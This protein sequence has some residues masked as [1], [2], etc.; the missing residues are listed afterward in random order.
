MNHL[1]FAIQLAIHHMSYYYWPCAAI[2][3]H[4]IH[5]LACH[6]LACQ[7]P[8]FLP[9]LSR[10]YGR[11]LLHKSV[12]HVTD[13]HPPLSVPSFLLV[14]R[15]FN[16]NFQSCPNHGVF[17]DAGNFGHRST[18]NFRHRSEAVACACSAVNSSLSTTVSRSSQCV[19]THS[20]NTSQVQ[21]RPSTNKNSSPF[22]LKRGGAGLVSK[23]K[24]TAW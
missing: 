1:L 11:S 18:N 5:Y 13:L 8:C 4:A 21:M 6:Y 20:T 9:C 23:T 14:V 19:T 15:W 16:V 12:R 2:C 7:L 10:S 17:D 22:F 24:R 3:H